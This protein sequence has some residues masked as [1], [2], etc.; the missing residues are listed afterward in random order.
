ML[1]VAVDVV[2]LVLVAFLQAVDNFSGVKS[3]ILPCVSGIKVEEK[4]ESK[5]IN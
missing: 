5:K 3:T 1:H 2:K 4:N